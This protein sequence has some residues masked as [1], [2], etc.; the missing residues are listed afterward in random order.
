[1]QGTAN[2]LNSVNKASSV[3]RV[4]LTSSIAATYGNSDDKP[5]E[6][7][8]YTEEDWNRTSTEAVRHFEADTDILLSTVA[9]A[10]R[11]RPAPD[12]PFRTGGPLPPLKTHGGGKG[13]GDEQGM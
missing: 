3:R 5:R 11:A 1:V 4:V 2:V 9:L 6:L 13:L 10:D 12:S 8:P 7:Q